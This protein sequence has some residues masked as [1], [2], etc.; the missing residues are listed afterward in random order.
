VADP[1]TKVVG[2]GGGK[3]SGGG[4][5]WP[6][7]TSFLIRFL[8][9]GCVVAA[10]L[11]IQFGDVQFRA[12]IRDNAFDQLQL[13][14][15]LPYR[16]EL[17]LRVIAIDDA[18][19]ATLGQWPWPRTVLAG[20]IDR[21]VG[22]GAKVIALDLVLSE[23]DRTSPEQ[24]AEFF[25]AQPALRAQ[26]LRL[27]THDRRL[28]ESF[29]GGKVV[30]G[31]P[32]IPGASAAPLPPA[33]A[34]FP[35]FGGQ[36]SDWLTPYGGGLASLPLL[37]AAASGSG[38]ISIEPDSDGVVRAMPLLYRIR[39]VL[40]PGL[41]LEALRLYLGL[42]NLPLKIVAADARAYGQVPGIQG[43]GLGADVFQPTAPDGRVWLRFRRLA[44]ERYLS[45]QD[46]VAGKLD[47]LLVKDHIVFVGATAKGLGDNIHTPLGELVPGVEGHVQLVEQLLADT[48]VLRPVWENDLLLVL[49]L[50]MWLALGGLLKRVRPIWSVVLITLAVAGLLAGS[51]WL[52]VAQQTLLD[53]FYPAL[54]V[55]LLFLVIMVPRYLQTESDQRWIRDAFSRYVSPNRVAYLQAN[56]QHLELGG[57][58]RECSFV[59]TDLAGFTTLME[60]HDSALLSDLLNDYLDGMIQIAFRHDGTLDRIVGDAVAV[61]FSAPL[62]Q[63]DHAARALACALEM[64]VFAN[65][66]SA[67]WQAQG[68]PFGRTRIGVNT[69]TVLVGNFGGR[70]M[71]DYR[72]LG[73]AI[74]TAAR[75][76]TVNGQIGTRICVSGTTVAQCANFVGRPIGNLVLKGKTEAVAAFEPL[77]TA[78]A[79]EP[80]VAE[81]LA[82]YAL[83]EAS[84]AKASS[85]FSALA[86]SYPDDP[87][88]AYHARRL[89]DGESGSSVVMKSK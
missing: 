50:G 63:V 74:N 55:S 38:A 71:L 28:A 34:R 81:Y 79:G 80:R 43:V 64:D 65:A 19:L 77:S 30:I 1:V 18:S 86:V 20:I 8:L 52:F 67:R 23:P 61:M 25:S 54:A 3:G 89:G 82:A 60:K 14:A 57:Q 6:R 31:F 56:P 45:A 35:N 46:V 39:D 4:R 2:T 16:E 73:D 44:P 83:M 24:V 15:P 40:Y 58:F 10:A 42:E 85:V 11:A 70:S 29:A 37:T 51:L 33:R 53:P 66:F 87:L 21:L 48:V 32:V 76:E 84:G 5:R 47:P 36:A 49:L 22:M 41:G 88:I 7:L 9:P 68:I 17:P 78:Q 62:T 26:L 27:P 59:M 12:R 69:G 72:A 75:L 13:L